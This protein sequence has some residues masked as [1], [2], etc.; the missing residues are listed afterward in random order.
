MKYDDMNGTHTTMKYV[1]LTEKFVISTDNELKDNVKNFTISRSQ[2]FIE[3]NYIY[4]Y[5]DN[6]NQLLFQYTETPDNY[7]YRIIK[8]T[9]QYTYD[10]GPLKLNNIF[11]YATL[12]TIDSDY[13]VPT[14]VRQIEPVSIVSGLSLSDVREYKYVSYILDKEIE[15][16]TST[17]SDISNNIEEPTESEEPYPLLFSI[18][19]VMLIIIR[20][21]TLNK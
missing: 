20:R 10:S 21:K 1:S 11:T 2:L 3:F 8:D 19:P 7:N 13:I 16:I 18:I 5:P 6:I 15:T 14:L 4:S 17:S 9:D 12:I